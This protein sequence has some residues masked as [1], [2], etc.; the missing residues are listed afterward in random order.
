MLA[1]M[2]YQ[3][4]RSNFLMI[5]ARIFGGSI[6]SAVWLL[7]TVCPGQ[8]TDPFH[9]HAQE[10]A[11]A[12]EL[13]AAS[14][15]ARKLELRPEPILRWTNPVPEKQMRG[16]VFLWTDDGRPAAVLNVFQM[17]EGSGPQ[18]C[19]EFCSLANDNLS[20]TQTAMRQWSP[21]SSHMRMAPVPNAPPPAI[22]PRQRLS[23]M[24]ELTSGF[25]CQKTNRKD[26]TQTLRLLS[27]PLIR[28]ES[29]LHGVADGALFTFVEAT[30]PEAYL[31]LEARV[32]GDSMQ[33]H[34]GFARMAS[35]KM[36]ASLDNKKVWE[37]DML[38][39][40]GYRNR[41]D[42]PYTLLIVR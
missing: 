36:Q 21:T 16:E 12:Y 13:L 39:Y 3:T 26:E 6:L 9:S 33:W 2:F 30:D 14:A 7:P 15:N 35:V 27:Q 28:Y 41:P 32:L 31:L 19:Y 40:T 37:V 25:L 34:F 5:F 23:Q 20:T 18:E 10:T 1:A 11:R 17:D 8:P 29:K 42:L 4:R 22:N 38:P 24:R